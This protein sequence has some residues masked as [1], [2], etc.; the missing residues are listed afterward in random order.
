MNIYLA[1]EDKD[2]YIIIFLQFENNTKIPSLILGYWNKRS[3]G[4]N[5]EIS[6]IYF[7]RDLISKNK[8]IYYIVQIIQLN[9]IGYLTFH[10]LLCAVYN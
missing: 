10:A 8:Q 2:G 9:K 3:F 5:G 4:T 1:F 7:Y 6:F